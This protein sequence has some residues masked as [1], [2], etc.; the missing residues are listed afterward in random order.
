MVYALFDIEVMSKCKKKLVLLQKP[1]NRV[2]QG[3]L[4]FG[5]IVSFVVR[6]L[7]LG[8]NRRNQNF[9]VETF[10]CGC[11][12]YYSSKHFDLTSMVV[13]RVGHWEKKMRK[14]KLSHQLRTCC[15]IL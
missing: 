6:N 9:A 10:S 12:F 14:A 7:C 15:V 11:W 1:N 5:C 4:L 8:T 3:A 2:L 13:K